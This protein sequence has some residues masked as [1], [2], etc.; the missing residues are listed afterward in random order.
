M[1]PKA[2]DF[3]DQQHLWIRVCEQLKL[4][5]KGDDRCIDT[6]NRLWRKNS[7]VKTKTGKVLLKIPHLTEEMLA[8]TLEHWSLAQLVA[9]E[10]PH[11]RNELKSFEP[12]IVLHWFGQNFLID[13]NTRVNFW[14]RVQNQGPHAVLKISEAKSAISQFVALAPDKSYQV[15]F[16]TT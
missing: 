2:S 4:H 7:R 14:E 15:E 11:D 5:N 8:V 13:G 9:L 16:S 1:S 10:P 3:V 6:L 12:I